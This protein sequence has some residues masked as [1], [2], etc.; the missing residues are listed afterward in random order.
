MSRGLRNC[1][2]FQFR[3]VQ[4]RPRHLELL[5]SLLEFQFRKV[6]LRQVRVLF[7]S[8]S[9]LF[10]F[11]KIQLRLKSHNQCSSDKEFQF[12][13]LLKTILPFTKK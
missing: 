3:K 7:G 12:R 11:C 10:Q 5:E 9:M 8:T 2:P 13:L 4:L 6:Q 1:N